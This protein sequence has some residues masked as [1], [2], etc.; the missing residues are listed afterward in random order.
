ML[1]ECAIR[2]LEEIHVV[3]KLDGTYKLLSCA[4]DV[5][6]L[7]C[8]IYTILNNTEASIHASE[9]VGVEVNAEKTKLCYC[10]SSSECRIKS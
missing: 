6:L 2:K 7:G 8:N 5:N 9:E 4:D 10:L 3:V 1:L